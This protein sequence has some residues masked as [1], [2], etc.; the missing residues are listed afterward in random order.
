MKKP[1]MNQPPICH[2]PQADPGP[3]NIFPPSTRNVRNPDNESAKNGY[4]VMSC[5]CS[6][7]NH[8][9][10]RNRTTELSFQQQQETVKY[11]ST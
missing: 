8:P 10:G 6:H 3:Q 1:G 7:R 9:S 2:P 11:P 4:C 5:D